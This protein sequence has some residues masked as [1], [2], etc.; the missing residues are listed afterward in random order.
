MVMSRIANLLPD[1]FLSR[2]LIKQVNLPIG[3]GGD[4]LIAGLPVLPVNAALF[5]VDRIILWNPL[6]NGVNGSLTA[7]LIGVFSGAGGVGTIAANQALTITGLLG[8]ASAQS[9][10]LTAAATFVYGAAGL[11]VNVGTPVAGG[12]LN[13]ALYGTV[14]NP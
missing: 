7:G 4:V 1:A 3:V 14:L 5:V 10:T 2:Q 8:A 6:V 9:L 13:I 12:T 11:Y